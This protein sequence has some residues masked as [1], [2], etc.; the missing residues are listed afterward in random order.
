MSNEKKIDTV[1]SAP[2]PGEAPSA[3]WKY[4]VNKGKNQERDLVHD[5]EKKEEKP[6]F[7]KRMFSGK[8]S[9]DKKPSETSKGAA[10]ISSIAKQD[11]LA[12]H[13]TE[14]PLKTYTTTAETSNANVYNADDNPEQRSLDEGYSK[15]PIG[16]T[17][18]DGSHVVSPPTSVL[19]QQQQQN[20]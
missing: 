14:K 11:G 20:K 1:G 9:E 16:T 4:N 2:K 8:Q 10:T 17:F 3:E 19:Q 7:F 18:A 15:F 6:G 5:S 12:T 13:D